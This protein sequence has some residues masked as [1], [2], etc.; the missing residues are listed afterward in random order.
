V[1]TISSARF[2]LLCR[3]IAGKVNARSGREHATRDSVL[4]ELLRSVE[5]HLG[6]KPGALLNGDPDPAVAVT[7]ALGTLVDAKGD[8]WLPIVEEEIFQKVGM[9][10]DQPGRAARQ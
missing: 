10:D 7:K 1:N 2:R 4:K 3:D 5:M 9:H 8:G 6:R